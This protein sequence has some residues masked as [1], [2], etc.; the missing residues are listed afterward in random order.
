MVMT[1]AINKEIAALR[2]EVRDMINAIFKLLD[3]LEKYEN[4]WQD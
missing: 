3:K 2:K 1:R 4:G